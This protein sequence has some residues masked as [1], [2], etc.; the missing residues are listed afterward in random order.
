MNLKILELGP[1]DSIASA[2][3]GFCHGASCI[4]LV[5]VD[6]YVTKDLNFYKRLISTLKSKG[7][8]TPNI[9]EANSIEDILT[10]C[11]CIYLTNGLA[12]LKTLRKNSIDYVWSHSVLEHIRKYQFFE[13][14]K[15]LKRLLKPSGL[16]SH[17]IDFQDHLDYGLNN[18]RFSEEIWESSFFANAGF[19]TNRIPALKMHS[20]FEKI[21]F[22]I[23]HK[24]LGKWPRLPTK[25][26]SMHREFDIFSDSELINRTSY[27]LLEK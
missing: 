14:Q 15:E 25:R 1:G 27:V 24:S 23:K 10:T 4:Y 21:G 20:I 5:D 18:L 11:N 13:V 17:S 26:S 7:L 9:S 2:I 12:S 8:K 3:I 19:Y 16:A 6:N 22:K